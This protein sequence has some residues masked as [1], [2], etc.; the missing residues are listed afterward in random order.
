MNAHPR[1]FILAAV[2]T[3]LALCGTA[4]AADVTVIG[5]R[6][7]AAVTKSLD[8]L[9]DAFDID[10]DYQ[11]IDPSGT[12]ETRHVRGI[13][14][15]ALLAAVDADP[16]YGG[17]QVVRP[18]S[19][20]VLVS[21]FQILAGSPAPAIY[22]DGENAVFVRPS[23]FAGDANV[24]DVI[25]AGVLA[26]R[27]TDS[28]PLQVEARASTAKTGV[29]KLV[30][31]N[32]SANG[33]AA[34][35]RCTFTW[36]FDDGSTATGP[37][38]SH[39]FIR[40]GHFDV[41]VTVTTDGSSRSDPDVVSVQVGETVKSGKQRK[42]GGTNA[43][44]GA[45]DSG[46]A[47]GASGPG[48]QADTDGDTANARS[49]VKTKRRMWRKRSSLSVAALP[50]ISGQ[51]IDAAASAHE[52]PTVAVAARNGRTEVRDSVRGG[53]PGEALGAV[54]VL[55][56]LGIGAALELGTP[57]RLRSRFGL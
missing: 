12:I 2:A 4:G 23:Y 11:I 25:A 13:S 56:L 36:N 27:Q 35:E 1:T 20:V 46:V 10:T 15:A 33:A 53:A 38:V 40:R 22:A 44:S 21:K 5:P 26:I 43:A 50:L 7:G 31:F 24:V 51:L 34:G 6:D 49:R 42:G 14:L 55:A 19:S 57:R 28:S 8:S 16:V 52:R 41:L 37:E 54:G 17:V 32:A 39:R 18:D 9:S 45:P 3:W 29:R 30:R 47:D 48:A